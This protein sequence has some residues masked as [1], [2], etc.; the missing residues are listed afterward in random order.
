MKKGLLSLVI[1]FAS[2]T[3]FCAGPAGDEKVND[4]RQIFW[5]AVKD[6]IWRDGTKVE[7]KRDGNSLT[8]NAYII[9]N[10][11]LTLG[12]VKLTNIN[13][14]FNDENRFYKVLITSDIKTYDEI[15]FILNYKFGDYKNES[16]VDNVHY[17]QWLVKDVT[18][19]LAKY[20]NS[21]VELIIESNWQ[22]SEDY[23]KNTNVSDF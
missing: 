10:D 14:I 22:A 9:P 16:N 4:F 19:T 21:R 7:F 1:V 15:F 5:G 11:N 23:K 12:A 18:F 2:F 8:K 3:A 6:S 17:I 20:E 13:Y